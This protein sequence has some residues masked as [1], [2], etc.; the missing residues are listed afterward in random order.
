MVGDT[1]RERHPEQFGEI[2]RFAQDKL[3]G[4]HLTKRFNL[5]PDER[6]VAVVR[7]SVL[8]YIGPASLALLSCFL[9]FFLIVPLF[10]RGRFGVSIFVLLLVLGVLMLFRTGWF[11]YWT[12]FVVTNTR[13]IDTDQ[14]GIFHRRI[15]EVRFEKVEDVSIEIRGIMATLFHLGSVRVQ[16]SGAQ[17]TIE[18]RTVPRPEIV[19]ELLGRLRG[20]VKA[21]TTPVTASTTNLMQLSKQDL[22]QLRVAIDAELQRRGTMPRPPGPPPP[23]ASS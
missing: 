11:W 9:A 8:A 16:T 14:R 4:M 22:E 1:A 7:R 23:H 6:V 18:L 15:S 17:S 12:A 13:I 3:N 21:R 2:L 10:A 19:H 5:R 20:E